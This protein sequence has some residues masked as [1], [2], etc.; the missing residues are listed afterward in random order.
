MSVVLS[1]L[2]SRLQASVPARNGVPSS[3]D[4]EQHVKDAVLQLSQDVPLRRTTELS[5]VAGTATYDLP[6]DFLFLVELASLCQPDSVFVSV[7]G[8]IPVPATWQERFEIV[9][10]EITFFPTPT[11]STTRTLRYAALYELSGEL[12]SEVY[13]TLTENGAR[14]AL[15]YAQYLALAQQGNSVAGSGWRY[16]IGDE[17]V[18]KSNQGKSYLAQA[19]ALL[20]QYQ[21]AVA[22]QK[23]Y[24][25]AGRRESWAC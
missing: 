7:D 24:G 16:Q 3:D 15:L 25:L 9:N 18:D 12:G 5:I 2:V 19:E 23:G 20:A 10:G 8:L 14:I 1:Y 6:G 22:Q 4:Y 13:T 21:R 11:Y 17:M